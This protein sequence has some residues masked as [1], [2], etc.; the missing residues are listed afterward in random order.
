MSRTYW[1]AVFKKAWTD[2]LHSLGWNQKTA[3]TVLVAVG[4]II[5]AFL[6]YGLDGLTQTITGYFWFAFGPVFAG[7]CLFI[8]NFVTAQA[9]LYEA[10]KVRI[11]ASREKISEL[12]AELARAKIVTKKDP[13]PDYAAWRHVQSITL[14]KAAFLWC[15]ME[16][17]SLPMPPK[18]AAWFNAFVG[19][20]QQGE[21]E[22]VPQ[23]S[24]HHDRSREARRQQD[25]PNSETIV[26]RD[27]LK[28]F[29]RR[30][31]YDP[32]FLRDA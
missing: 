24:S 8:W 23:Y 7:L 30:H 5:L 14:R 32:I 6:R 2:T 12:E 17:A 19:A 11:E 31:G 15:D 20:V 28:A 13:L 4:A 1:G 9:S 22:F 16:P 29:A 21:L 10:S 25:T 18:V 27:Q 3:A 26:T